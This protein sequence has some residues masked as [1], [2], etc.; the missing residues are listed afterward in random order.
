M[1]WKEL[2]DRIYKILQ[3]IDL[4]DREKAELIL[5]EFNQYEPTA[6]PLEVSMLPLRD[7]INDLLSESI[8]HYM[9]NN[10]SC[11]EIVNLIMNEI[12]KKSVI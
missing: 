1:L 9:E 10:I 3:N 4:T 11:I 7:R 5:I 12:N 2:E 8:Y 6:K